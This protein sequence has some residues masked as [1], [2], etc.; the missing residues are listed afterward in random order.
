M[1]IVK[2]YWLSQSYKSDVPLQTR[3]TIKSGGLLYQN[4]LCSCYARWR[5]VSCQHNIFYI[6]YSNVF[7]YLFVRNSFFLLYK[8]LE[9]I[10]GNAIIM[11]SSDMFL[12]KFVSK[13]HSSFLSVVFVYPSSWKKN[14]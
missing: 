2:Y 14:F 4:I 3:S 10:S 13:I 6:I 12:S 1:S 9:N 7:V 11:R 8:H 5:N